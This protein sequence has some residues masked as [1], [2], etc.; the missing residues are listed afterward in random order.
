MDK[1]TMTPEQKLLTA[2]ALLPVLADFLEDYPMRF[3]AKHEQTKLITAIRGFDKFF[4]DSAGK[5]EREQQI[6]FQRWFRGVISEEFS[7]LVTK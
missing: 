2:Q 4:M 6:D 1:Q 3:T 7:K 5:E